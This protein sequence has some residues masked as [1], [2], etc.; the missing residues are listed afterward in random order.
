MV[1]TSLFDLRGTYLVKYDRH[2]MKSDHWISGI[3][4]GASVEIHFLYPTLSNQIKSSGSHSQQMSV[5]SRSL[6]A[7]VRAFGDVWSVH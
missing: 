4:D 6:S 1:I 7:D 5:I 2:C 3:M